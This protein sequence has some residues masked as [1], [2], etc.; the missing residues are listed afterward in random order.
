MEDGKVPL[1]RVVAPSESAMAR[2]ERGPKTGDDAVV[3]R[4]SLV[5]LG[6]QTQTPSW[7]LSLCARRKENELRPWMENGMRRSWRSSGFQRELL[8]STT[9]PVSPGTA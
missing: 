8:R 4:H 2:T 1:H 6:S 3:D 5:P 7:T 9:R